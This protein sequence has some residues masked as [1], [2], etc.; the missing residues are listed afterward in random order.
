M[1]WFEE[2]IKERK[3]QDNDLFSDS[4]LKI[5]D[6]ISGKKDFQNVTEISESEIHAILHYFGYNTKTEVPK[7]MVDVHEQLAFLCRPYGLMFR[8]VNLSDKWWKDCTGPILAFHREDERVIALIP[9]WLGYYFYQDGKKVRVNQKNSQVIDSSGYCFYQSFP[10]RKLNLLD[11]VKFALCTRSVQDIVLTLSFMGISTLIGLLVPKITY[12]LYSTVVEEKSS[13]LL[14]TT[15]VFFI[16]VGISSLLFETFRKM[17]D[18]I[19]STKMEIS[20]QS[21]TMMR[22]LSMPVSF[23]KKYSSGELADRSGYLTL[24][25]QMLMNT[26]FGTGL[27]SLFSLAYI[28]SVFQYAP[29]LVI[30]AFLLILINV[31]FSIFVIFSRQKITKDVME[32]HSKESGMTY[33]MISGIKKIK[34][35]GAERRAFARWADLY[36]KEIGKVYNPP[37]FIK[38]SDVISLA[39]SAFS[40][41]VMYYFA[42]DSGVK[43]AEYTAFSAAY[44]IL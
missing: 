8:E 5:A 31:T 33:A 6:A 32:M 25:T 41:L 10:N 29:K 7:D 39:I 15:M 42:I 34:I 43:V 37:S 17:Y 21:A 22:V 4:I 38:I 24:L 11:L 26:L 28:S 35:A 16:S 9:D 30:P 14:I 18:G 27:S 1:S 36:A 3:Q 40:T 19:I 13:Q 20:L 44:G 23:F 2:Q 12:F